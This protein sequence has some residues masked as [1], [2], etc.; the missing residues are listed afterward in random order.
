MAPGNAPV[1]MYWLSL[2]ANTT[3]SRPVAPA[4]ASSWILPVL[5][6]LEMNRFRLG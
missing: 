2:P 6:T 1:L 3:V 5:C 4:K